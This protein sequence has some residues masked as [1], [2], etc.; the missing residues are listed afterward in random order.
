[1]LSVEN[2]VAFSL[3]ASSLCMVGEEGSKRTRPALASPFSCCS[4]VTSWDSPN[5]RACSQPM[6]SVAT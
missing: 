6:S 2:L 4:P 5:W 3:L 1:M